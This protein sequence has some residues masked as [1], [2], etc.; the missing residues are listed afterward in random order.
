MRDTASPEVLP[1]KME[2]L[3]QQTHQ[4]LNERI[5]TNVRLPLDLNFI[6]VHIVA[7]TV[8]FKL[9]IFIDWNVINN[10][11]RRRSNAMRK[12]IW[13]IEGH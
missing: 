6:G 12:F 13:R 3:G 2:T 4:W 9:Y 7:L 1:F 11:L 10:F 8:A 5:H